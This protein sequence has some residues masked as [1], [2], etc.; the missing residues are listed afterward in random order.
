MDIILLILGFLLL[1]KGADFLVDGGASLAKKLNIPTIVIG[2][3]I[4]AFGTSAPELVVNLIAS[5][6][7]NT[8][9]ALGNIL[10]SN[11]FN[12]LTILGISSLISNIKV[13]RTTTII[14]I[15]IVILSSII[16]LIISNDAFIDQKAY[17]EISKIDG[18]ILLIFFVLFM[19]YNIYIALKK[20]FELGE[21]IKSLSIKVSICYIFI[22]LIFLIVGGRFVVNSSVNIARFF[23][24]SERVIGLTI[25]AIGTS[26]PELIT[27]IVASFKK[28]TDIAVGNILG[29][30]IFNSLFIIGISSLISNIP[31]KGINQYD[32]LINFIASFLIFIF[33]FTGKKHELEKWEGSLFI[34]LQIF[35]FISLFF[36]Q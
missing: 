15:P 11:I 18:L 19:A 32:L 3:T 4:V 20:D 12:I 7:N 33:L 6:R 34:T 24:I 25:V 28:F 1:V 13:S 29:S 36:I 2:L 23:G 35:Y 17:S 21:E 5:L 16:L 14:E 22:G 8:D 26:L 9:I 31:V 30:N 27:S 10:G